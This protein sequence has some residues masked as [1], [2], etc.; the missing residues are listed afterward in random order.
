MSLAHCEE[1]NNTHI[2]NLILHAS[3]HVLLLIGFAA[4]PFAARCPSL[5]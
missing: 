2:L 3:P 1:Y 5:Y 4:A